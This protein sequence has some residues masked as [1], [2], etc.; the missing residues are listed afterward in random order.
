MA[1]FIDN[2]RAVLRPGRVGRKLSTTLLAMGMALATSSALGQVAMLTSPPPIFNPAAVGI[3][4]S[5]AQ[6]ITAKFNVTGYAGN[7]T[8]TAKLRYGLSYSLGAVNCT[9]GPAPE[10]C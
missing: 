7:F 5:S 4:H 10:S 3:S 2:T 8:P 6:T 1:S 9:G